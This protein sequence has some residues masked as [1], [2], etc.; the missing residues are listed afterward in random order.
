MELLQRVPLL[1]P[2]Y[3]RPL[4]LHLYIILAFTHAKEEI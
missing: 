1:L 3:P 2:F 4:L